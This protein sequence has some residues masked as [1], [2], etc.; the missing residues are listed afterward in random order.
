M[1]FIR[2]LVRSAGGTGRTLSVAPSASLRPRSPVAADL[3][4]VVHYCRSHQAV[5]RQ[6]SRQLS[7]TRFLVLLGLFGVWRGLSFL[8][9]AHWRYVHLVIVRAS[10]SE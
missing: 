4:R 3:R 7:R 1:E 9:S 2:V 10:V 5:L 8:S 6:L